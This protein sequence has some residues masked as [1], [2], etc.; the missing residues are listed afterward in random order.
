M[1]HSRSSLTTCLE[2]GRILGFNDIKILG[3][4]IFQKNYYFKYLNKLLAIVN[5]SIQIFIH[6]I[7]MILTEDPLIKLMY[8]LRIT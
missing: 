8:K 7:L 5:S 6:L 1:S 4:D 2:L 3:Y